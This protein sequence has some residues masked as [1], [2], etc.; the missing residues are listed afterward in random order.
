MLSQ[1]APGMIRQFFFFP[2]LTFSGRAHIFF[3]HLAC[4]SNCQGQTQYLLSRRLYLM[5]KDSRY[6]IFFCYNSYEG[7]K[8]MIEN[9]ATGEKYLR[10]GSL[11]Y[12]SKRGAFELN[13][14]DEKTKHI[15]HLRGEKSK[16]NKYKVLVTQISEVAVWPAT[17]FL[18]A[19]LPSQSFLLDL[20]HLPKL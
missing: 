3:K 13:L 5:D 16:G 2:L 14:N 17:I 8:T 7:N 9:S 12:F 11:N 20:L 4:P 10:L 6:K 1:S 19:A 15:K 18:S